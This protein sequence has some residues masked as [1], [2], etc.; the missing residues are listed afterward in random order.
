MNMVI[1][2]YRYVSSGCLYFSHFIMATWQ[3]LLQNGHPT[4]VT[5][6]RGWTPLHV[7]AS[8]GCVEA[9]RHLLMAG[10][11]TVPLFYHCSCGYFF[12]C[13]ESSHHF[14]FGG[15][16]SFSSYLWKATYVKPTESLCVPQ[17]ISLSHHTTLF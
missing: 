3:E 7:A 17:L 14:T 2:T 12:F 8:E 16:A 9:V 1:Y 10:T 15:G 6:N 11:Y 13:Y 5:D 4:S